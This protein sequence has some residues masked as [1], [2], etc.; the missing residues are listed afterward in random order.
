MV[1]IFYLETS[2]TKYAVTQRH[3]PEEQIPHLWPSETPQNRRLWGK[4]VTFVTVQIFRIQN[5]NVA[6]VRGFSLVLKFEGG[7]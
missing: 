5:I 6:A 3:I 2:G 7:E 4:S 1:E